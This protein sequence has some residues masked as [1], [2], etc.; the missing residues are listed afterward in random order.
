MMLSPLKVATLPYDSI[1]GSF[2]GGGGG[3]G[4][5]VFIKLIEKTFSD[6]WL[7]IIPTKDRPFGIIF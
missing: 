4:G 5:G 6:P 7:A 3:G 2:R 1:R